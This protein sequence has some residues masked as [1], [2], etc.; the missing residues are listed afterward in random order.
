MQLEQGVDVGVAE[1]VGLGLGLAEGVSDGVAD[2]KTVQVWQG[3]IPSYWPEQVMTWQGG[4]VGVIVGVR[5]LGGGVPTT[6]PNVSLH[7]VIWQGLTIAY[8][9][10]QSAEASEAEIPGGAEIVNVMESLSPDPVPSP[11]NSTK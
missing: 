9:S 11:P 7:P 1:G 4:S 6:R 10:L 5:Q 8:K 3:F 2:G